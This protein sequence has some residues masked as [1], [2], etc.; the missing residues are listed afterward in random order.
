MMALQNGHKEVA[1]TLMDA[2]AHRLATDSVGD[3]VMAV[4]SA[5]V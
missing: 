1:R 5:G 4:C 3:S 2:G